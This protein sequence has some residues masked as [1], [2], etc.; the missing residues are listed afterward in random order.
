MS[1][2]FTHE[3]TVNT[4][5]EYYTP[6]HIFDMLGVVFDMDVASPLE[7][8]LPWIPAVRHLTSKEDGLASP[9]V[10]FVW[11]N[12]PY[13]KETIKW[14]KKMSE[15]KNGI[16][17]VFARTDTN[18]FHNHV[19]TADAILFLNKRIKFVDRDQNEGGSPGCGSMLIAWG[20]EGT[21]TLVA[22][23][24]KYKLGMIVRP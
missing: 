13:G 9:W 11:C 14:L 1:T 6:K 19:T 5:I 7:G 22:A 8:P 3:K 21:K 2:G 24:N 10:G 12:P 17:L 15:H 20:E 18:W 23:N 16:A 4:S